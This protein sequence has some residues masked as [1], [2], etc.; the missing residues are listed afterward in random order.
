[1]SLPV[2]DQTS[3]YLVCSRHVPL[4]NATPVSC[5]PFAPSSDERPAGRPYGQAKLP[6]HDKVVSDIYTVFVGDTAS[7]IG[8]LSDY[9]RD[10]KEP[11][12]G[13][14]DAAH[15]DGGEALRFF[16]AFMAN[17]MSGAG[18]KGRGKRKQK[19]NDE[20]GPPKETPTNITR[21]Q[22]GT[23]I[24]D[25]LE[26]WQRSETTDFPR[27]AE[28]EAIDSGA[29]TRVLRG[30]LLEMC[31]AVGDLMPVK[32]VLSC[33]LYSLVHRAIAAAPPSSSVTTDQTVL[34]ALL[35]CFRRFAAAPPGAGA[36]R[37]IAFDEAVRTNTANAPSSSSS[38]LPERMGGAFLVLYNKG[39]DKTETYYLAPDGKSV[40]TRMLSHSRTHNAWPQLVA[41]IQSVVDGYNENRYG[42]LEQK[43]LTRTVYYVNQLTEQV[44]TSL[45]L[46][47]DPKYVK[48]AH[49][50]LR[51]LDPYT[52]PASPGTVV[53]VDALV[54]WLYKR[55][56]DPMLET[57]WTADL[58][59]DNAPDIALLPLDTAQD[60]VGRTD[61]YRHTPFEA[62]KGAWF[63]MMHKFN[64]HP[65]T[66]SRLIESFQT[67]V[68]FLHDPNAAFEQQ[69]T[70]ADAGRY[71][72]VT[73]FRSVDPTK[74]KTPMYVTSRNDYVALGEASAVD[75]ADSFLDTYM[76]EMT[77]Q[78]P[79]APQQV[80][81]WLPRD[82]HNGAL[83]YANMAAH[84]NELI[85]RLKRRGDRAS[86]YDYRKLCNTVVFVENRIDAC[87]GRRY[88]PV[89]E[90]HGN[91]IVGCAKRLCSRLD[92]LT[93]GADARVDAA[94]VQDFVELVHLRYFAPDVLQDIE[95]RC[96]VDKG[97]SSNH[98]EDLSI[99]HT[100]GVL[101]GSLAH[102]LNVYLSMV[103]DDRARRAYD[104]FAACLS[105]FG[106]L[107]HR[108]V[109][110]DVDLEG[111]VVK[112][113]GN[114]SCVRY[115]QYIGGG[116]DDDDDDNPYYNDYV[117]NVE[118][119]VDND[120][121]TCA[122][123]ARD[124]R[125]HGRNVL[126]AVK[127]MQQKVYRATA[128]DYDEST[129]E[130]TSPDFADVRPGCSIVSGLISCLS[131]MVRAN[132]TL[133]SVCD[134]YNTM[135]N[136][137][138]EYTQRVVEFATWM[139]TYDMSLNPGAMP[140]FYRVGADV[141]DVGATHRL[142]VG[143]TRTCKGADLHE[144]KRESY[145]HWGAG[146]GGNLDMDVPSLMSPL[147]SSAFHANPV[148][149]MRD[150]FFCAMLGPDQIPPGVLDGVDAEDL[151][152]HVVGATSRATVSSYFGRLVLGL[153]Q[154]CG[155]A[156]PWVYS[157]PR[158]ALAS[159]LRDAV[160]RDVSETLN[161][162]K[163]GASPTRV[164]H[165]YFTAVFR[166]EDYGLKH[167]LFAYVCACT[168]STARL[169]TVFAGYVR[170][171]L[172][173]Y[174]EM[175]SGTPGTFADC[176]RR[177]FGTTIDDTVDLKLLF[178]FYTGSV[179]SV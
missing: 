160:R 171:M 60:M 112:A 98:L 150:N 88:V 33:N 87:I 43:C 153:R 97:A 139:Y 167:V 22:V 11:S 101:V 74:G 118:P 137:P 172:A 127:Y 39:G 83:L 26:A 21:L 90:Y 105:E 54:A 89:S 75:G 5:L 18:K 56:L 119:L 71:G 135:R 40:L 169:P 30:I 143:L 20:A 64:V 78:L 92:A 84:S 122:A 178:A 82:V 91:A 19:A 10:E 7:Y 1:M 81:T 133:A 173:K 15:T 16:A 124:M 23:W 141:V 164:V 152:G 123:V 51:L 34:C 80:C 130:E 148:D 50:A 120:M 107:C 144:W 159:P 170:N 69:D 110:S 106:I 58:D 13:Y 29:A 67:S 157:P 46:L 41:K 151:F 73:R 65:D 95:S 2:L 94:D 44:F 37:Y 14:H 79:L 93:V 109:D 147:G 32:H 52:A 62:P 155:A 48:H 104:A 66:V 114:D 4:S 55:P 57:E 126:L 72:C 162:L 6:A 8:A 113:Y 27:D 175:C 25:T 12:K 121:T 125:T 168:V 140:I 42:F 77:A 86:A 132:F 99:V 166:A 53:E 136:A 100:H 174:D 177:Y 138:S 179:A 176:T 116:D 102:C 45:S 115:R 68:P 146:S 70:Y 35:C 85:T 149:A 129:D 145:E 96:N 9:V 76:Y 154:W 59:G 161:L 36:D 3:T 163:V 142:L 103:G 63:S 134:L 131:D 61:V 158:V 165:R 47:H 49:Y 111:S 156:K 28:T 38:R 108:P 24:D 31:R 17:A 128:N 117:A